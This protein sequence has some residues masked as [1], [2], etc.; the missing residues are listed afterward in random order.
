M[1]T[2]KPFVISKQIVWEAYRRV[3]ARQGAAGVDGQSIA[4]FEE[5]LKDNLYKIWNRMS[6]G[7]YFP[8]PVR[9][10]TIPK[11]HG[12]GQRKLGIPT[13]GDRVAQTVAAMYLEPVVEPLFHEDSYG[14]RPGKSAHQAVTVARKRCWENDWVVDL[15]IAAFFDTLDHEVI[16]R[17]VRMHTEERWI[18]L[19]IERWL[20]A[21]L[22]ED[23]NIVDRDR[24]TPQGSAISPL[25]ANIV[26]HHAFDDWMQ[27]TFASVPFERYA[28]DIVVHCK[29]EKQAVE[30]RE[31][32]A[33][34]LLRCR[35]SL[36]PTKTRI[37]Y[38]KDGKRRGSYV[39]EQF[40]FLG[41]TFRP[42]RA[43]GRNG[44]FV[45]FSPAISNSAATAMRQTIRRWN[46]HTRS[47][48]GIADH[49]HLLNPK[50][51][52][53]NNYYGRFY[54][55]EF[56][57]ALHSIDPILVRWAMRKYKRLRGKR[58]SAWKWLKRVQAQQPTLFLHWQYG[59]RPRT[60]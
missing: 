52:G 14:Y 46:M 16:M 12:N 42:R 19:Y 3:R 35:L 11:Q 26:M 53:W 17:A 9:S 18:L 49:A 31:A 55:S 40:D 57:A 30:I 54:K 2:A 21:P 4:Q 36:H 34:R 50:V 7:T 15:D 44:V 24:G 43:F 25:I 39:H 48:L 37:V 8:P 41:F 13:V 29:T 22:S 51:R 60:G 27:T 20:K 56:S 33:K 28:D 23:G 32:I 58:T 1:S 47:D 59:A 45:N 38:C 10:V 5:K 6:S